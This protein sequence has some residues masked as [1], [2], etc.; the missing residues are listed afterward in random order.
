MENVKEVHI[1]LVEDDPGDQKLIRNSLA[2]QKISNELSIAE[3]GEDALDYLSRSI[4]G[5]SDCL[6]PDLIL[7]DLNMPGMGG[8]EFLKRIKAD[9]Q[10]DTIPVVILT[11][12]DSDQDILDTYK[13]HS[14]GYI[15]K[16]VSLQGFQ[17]IMSQLENYWFTICRRVSVDQLTCSTT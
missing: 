6:F 12:S 5:D 3:N 13:L 4:N 11:T 8:K 14:A 2:K 9:S 17:E 15:K 7:L 16:P 1:L 10:L